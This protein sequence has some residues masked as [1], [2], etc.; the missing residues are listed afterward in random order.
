MFRALATAAI[1]VWFTASVMASVKA[2]ANPATPGNSQ[3]VTGCLQ[4]GQTTNGFRL[5]DVQGTG[6]K[7]VQIESVPPGTDLRTYLGQKVVITGTRVDSHPIG[8]I[9]IADKL[10]V[11]EPAIRV[12]SVKT[13]STPCR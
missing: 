13:L 9:P 8:K 3:T 6:P 4:K 10:V 5:S 12:L 11:A 2:I 1:A 7:Q